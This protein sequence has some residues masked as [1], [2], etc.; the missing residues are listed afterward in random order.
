MYEPNVV[1][2]P[3]LFEDILLEAHYSRFIVHLGLVKKYQDAD[4]IGSKDALSFSRSRTYNHCHCQSGS[5]TAL[6][7]IL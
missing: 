2:Y 7:I 6:H 5:G 1:A 3:R 4:L